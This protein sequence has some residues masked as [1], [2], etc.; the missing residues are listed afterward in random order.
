MDE[1]ALARNLSDKPH[2]NRF[3]FFGIII[4]WQAIISQRHFHTI[5]TFVIEMKN[6]GFN[7]STKK[8]FI[9]EPN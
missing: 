8:L 4:D 6:Y 2:S 9:L 3:N 1:M 7:K 5:A